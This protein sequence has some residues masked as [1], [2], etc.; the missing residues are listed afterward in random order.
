[1]T[2][3]TRLAAIMVRMLNVP[4][5]AARGVYHHSLPNCGFSINTE[6]EE[7]ERKGMRGFTFGAGTRS[8]PRTSG[9]MKRDTSHPQARRRKVRSCQSATKEKMRRVLRKRW[10]EPPRG[11]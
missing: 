3:P 2:N 9:R 5:R 7:T 10:E 6:G 1:M 11:M 8:P 4:P